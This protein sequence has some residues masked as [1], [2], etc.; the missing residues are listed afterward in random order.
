MKPK[1]NLG[2]VV[3]PSGTMS[4]AS[5][6]QAGVGGKLP[7]E[8]SRGRRRW[9]FPT[10]L[11]PLILTPAIIATMIFV[12]GFIAL[13][14]WVSLSKWGSLRMNLDLRQPFG[15]TY[16]QMFAMPRWHANLRNVFVFTTL[17]LTSSIGFGLLLAMLLD[18]KLVGHT[19]LRNI[20]LFP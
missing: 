14:L 11:P 12:Y 15:L 17:F 3:V 19:V 6:T 5:P 18:R 16:Q 13:T 4:P 1:E 20:F 2:V 9:S 8:V 10:L 7:A